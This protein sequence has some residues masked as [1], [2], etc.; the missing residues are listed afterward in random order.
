MV[1]TKTHL[2]ANNEV[3]K[4]LHPKIQLVMESTKQVKRQ[5]GNGNSFES[6]V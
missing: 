6:E 1:L 5:G 2:S 4:H 3:E